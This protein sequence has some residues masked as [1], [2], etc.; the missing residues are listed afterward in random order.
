MIIHG[1]ARAL[2][3]ADNSVHCCVTSP[4]YWKQRDYGYPEQLGQ[5]STLA[6]Y[7]QGQVDVFD[8]VRRVLK[9]DGTLWLNLGDAYANS[10]RTRSLAD[11][12]KGCT[13]TGM[14]RGQMTLLRQ[15]SRLGS[16]FARKQ[17]LGLPW[18]VAMALQEAG[19]YLRADIIW[20]K[21]NGLPSNV[22]DRPTTAH[23][24]IF[25]LAKRSRY[26]Y[27]QKTVAEVAVD[28][29]SKGKARSK[30]NSGEEHGHRPHSGLNGIYPTRNL[31]DVWPMAT[32]HSESDHYA[33][34]PAELARKCILAGCPEG[35]IVLDPF[36]G[37]GTTVAVA[38]ELGRRG[39]GVERGKHYLGMARR[40]TAQGMLF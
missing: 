28:C 30:Y 26:Y 21:T 8:E 31:R 3:L 25:L 37:S 36:V 9:P 14:P 33:V 19:W 7:I 38:R 11:S 35:G 13:L 23:E 17:L 18:R 34:F 39:V 12:V 15:G 16:G 32:S 4:P 29:R 10:G 24:Y 2:P 22:A 5:E 1:D 27:D 6:D 20:H 40:K